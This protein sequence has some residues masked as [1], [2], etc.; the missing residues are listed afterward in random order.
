MK[1]YTIVTN[2]NTV[3]IYEIQASSEKEAKKLFN[4]DPEKAKLLSEEDDGEQIT[5]IEEN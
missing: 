4:Q 3:R 2:A 5:E 1:T